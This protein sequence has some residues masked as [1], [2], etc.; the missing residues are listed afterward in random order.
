[1]R[2]KYF[3]L[4]SLILIAA[5]IVIATVGCKD[6]K[7]TDTS[8]KSFTFVVCDAAGTETVFD[9]KSDKSTVGEAL[10]AEGLIE[11]EDSQYGLYVK[12]VNGIE[13]V[14]EKDGTYWS[15]Y[16][17]GEYAMTG[18]DTTPIEDGKCYMF[19]VEGN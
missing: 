10:L 14:Y 16:I 8:E 2:K 6:K 13:A 12:K 18:V 5:M 17:D 19:K 9:L 15:F 11:G 3:K 7:V 4:L 1:M